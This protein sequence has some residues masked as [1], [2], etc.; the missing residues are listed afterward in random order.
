MEHRAP[1]DP[2]QTI[3]VTGERFVP[4]GSGHEPGSFDDRLHVA[5]YRLAATLVGGR[6]LDVACGTGYGSAELLRHGCDQVVGVDVDEGAVGYASAHYPGPTFVKADAHSLPFDDGF[7]TGVVSFETIEH[8]ERPELFLQELDRVTTPGSVLILSTP[9]YRGGEYSTPFHIREF[10]RHELETLLRDA[11]GAATVEW[12]GQLDA[13]RESVFRAMG[14]AMIRLVKLLDPFN[15]RYRVLHHRFRS[16]VSHYALGISTSPNEIFPWRRTALYTV[17]VVRKSGTPAHGDK[18]ECTEGSE[19]AVDRTPLVSIVI[20]TKNV[21]DTLPA[22]LASIAAL[23][24]PKDR[25][26]VVVADGRSSDGTIQIAS[27]AGARIVDDGGRG[28]CRVF[29]LNA[30]L[31]TVNAAY[32]AF[33]DADCRISP[34]WLRTGLRNFEDPLVAGVGGP[35]PADANSSL[36]SRAI[37]TTMALVPTPNVPPMERDVMHLPGCNAIYRVDALRRV[38]PLPEVECDDVALSKR[39]RALGLKLRHAPSMIVLHSPHYGSLRQF[40]RH[41]RL[42]GYARRELEEYDLGWRTWPGTLAKRSLIWMPAVAMV[43]LIGLSSASG[44]WAPLV[45]IQLFAVVLVMLTALRRSRS[46]GIMA[47][48]VPLLFIGALAY[49]WGYLT[50]GRFDTVGPASRVS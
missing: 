35:V 27:S 18:A 14:Q 33:L 44:V 7:F 26:E 20:P 46:W 32:A 49:S 37:L 36:L 48:S 6:V 4:G 40:A 45:L 30:A 2:E 31:P 42:Y 34:D 16:S 41:M 29:G 50:A 11:F 28:R 19:D 10:R 47:L 5:R 12:L 24:Y 22:C 8:L 43:D 13:G 39:V 38:F 9:N 17:A 3:E 21:A 25:Y 1:H 23:D 15:L